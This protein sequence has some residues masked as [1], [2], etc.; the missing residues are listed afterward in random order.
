MDN[1]TPSHQ[2]EI[3]HIS[4][5]IPIFR[6]R[7][8]LILWF[9]ALAVAGTT[10]RHIFW[11]PLYEAQ[12]KLTIQKSDNVPMQLMTLS[13]YMPGASEGVDRIKKYVDY[14]NTDE[15][16]RN[17]AQTLKFRDGYNLLN[18]TSPQELA[19][20]KKKFWEQFRNQTFGRKASPG[21]PKN[22]TREPVLVPIEDLANII[23][24]MTNSQADGADSIRIFV[25]SLDP[26]TSM[27]LVNT[28]S[29]VFVL[30][31][32]ER[33][34]NEVSE[35]RKFIENQLDITTDR[36]KKNETALVEFKKKHN[37]ISLANEHSHVSQKVSNIEGE[38]EN[39][40]IKFQENQRLI[41]HF[42][43]LLS[44]NENQILSQGS[45]AIQGSQAD[46]V[47][48]L[49]QQL[50][51]LRYKKVLMQAQGFAENS[52]QMT[53]IDKD[54]DKFANQLK[55]YVASG[56]G[57]AISTD[58]DETAVN[59]E[60]ARFKMKNLKTENK[61][62][63]AK[64]SAI[65]RSREEVLKSL[66]SLPKEEQILLTLKRDVDLQFELYSTMKKKLQ[67]VEIQQVALQSRV[68]I[69]DRSDLP[70]QKSRTHF[71]LKIIFAFLIG[72][73]LGGSVSLILEVLD[74][75]VKHSSELDKLG[76]KAIGE[77]P[78]FVN[79]TLDNSHT[80]FSGRSHFLLCK[81][82]QDSTPAM[83]F[84]H[85]RAQ[86]TSSRKTDGNQNK[87]ILVSGPENGDGKTFVAS[88]LAFSIAQLEKRVLLLDCDLRHPG[89]QNYFGYKYGEGLTSLLSLKVNL[90]QAI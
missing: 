18:L 14:L 90:E 2:D 79:T 63:Q 82:F 43:K 33:D 24:S 37:I 69:S 75:S 4:E 85:I 49:R 20:T 89:V 38:L 39:N 65:E 87:V 74:T 13:G 71:L 3:F 45:A 32:A 61:T 86:I 12:S 25:N 59:L 54:I 40:R 46:S 77:I 27:V 6:M 42:E 66:E 30:K 8:K 76:L 68:M 36:L 29:D 62:L 72:A 7:R 44:K 56:G 28:I 57:A 53:Q 22:L 19:L 31:T 11:I 48:R 58:E 50:D 83:A 1:K 73:F 52:W 47:Q 41:D 21:E 34:H 35:V 23:H 64:I 17:V 9:I 67:E 80:T 78:H 5:L 26:F 88:N 10:F 15:F 70:P 84:K 51:S 60:L 81:E 55:N 16:F